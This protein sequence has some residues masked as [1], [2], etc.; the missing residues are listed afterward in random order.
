L[1]E[2][3]Q[4]PPAALKVNVA[5]GAESAALNIANPALAAINAAAARRRE[6]IR[7]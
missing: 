7:F 3:C 4:S 1:A 2:V 6:T 5:P